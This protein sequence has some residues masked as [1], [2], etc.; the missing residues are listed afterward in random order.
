MTFII[1]LLV[2]MWFHYVDLHAFKRK[3][4][5][6]SKAKR[7]CNNH[8][9]NHIEKE[10]T[11][12]YLNSSMNWTNIFYKADVQ[13]AFID[14]RIKRTN[15]IRS[16]NFVMKIA[17][18]QTVF[19]TVYT[20]VHLLMFHKCLK[21]FRFDVVVYI[22]LCSVFSFY[23][24]FVIKLSDRKFDLSP[25]SLDLSLFRSDNI[26]YW[27]QSKCYLYKFQNSSGYS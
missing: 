8:K 18:V 7:M 1:N 4:S 5:K 11:K 20:S 6:T 26:L 27:T 24:K 12:E 3:I 14:S 16:M 9:L 21:K 17:S 22:I 15:E 19:Y 10:N 23:Y 13:E 2:L 25:L